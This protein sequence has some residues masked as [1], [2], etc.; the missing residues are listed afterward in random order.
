MAGCI[1]E[2]LESTER[3]GVLLFLGDH[4]PAMPAVFAAFG[5]SNPWRHP[6]LHK[7]P[8]VL[9]RGRGSGTGPVD[10]AVSALPA[11]LLEAA[12]LPLDDFLMAS[13][14]LQQHCIQSTATGALPGDDP[15]CPTSPEAAMLALVRQR[16]RPFGKGEVPVQ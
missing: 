9:W 13:R 8:Y 16:L 12:G 14:Y 6:A 1:I 3:P 2:G 4:A 11:A 10:T 7:V 15:L 5:V